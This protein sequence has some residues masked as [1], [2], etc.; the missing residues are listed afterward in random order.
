M[1]S[2]VSSPIIFLMYIVLSPMYLELNMVPKFGLELWALCILLVWTICGA[3]VY[4]SFSYVCI[5]DVLIS[6]ELISCGIYDQRRESKI[7]LVNN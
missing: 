4:C 6:S 5:S 3:H 7:K 2:V 1:Q